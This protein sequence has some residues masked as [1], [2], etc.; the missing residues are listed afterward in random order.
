MNA[1]DLQP[2]PENIVQTFRADALGRNEDIFAFVDLLKSIKSNYS[3]ALDGT[4]GS[5]KTFFV[6]QLVMFLDVYTDNQSSVYKDSFQE[7]RRYLNSD[8]NYEPQKIHA[9]Y[10]DAWAN[11]NDDDPILSIIFNILQSQ[12][13]KMDKATDWKGILGGIANIITGRP[14][15]D[16]INVAPKDNFLEEIE[17]TKNIHALVNS[18]F[19]NLFTSTESERIVIFI[20]EL[21]RCKPSYAITL[22]ERIKHY[23]THEKITFVFSTNLNELQYTVK[24]CYGSEFSGY[25]YLEKF[26]TIIYD[27]AKVD[28]DKINHLLKIPE[29]THLFI[30]IMS[31]IKSYKLQL[32]EALKYTTHLKSILPQE[33]SSHDNYRI[34]SK[35]EG[36]K[37]YIFIP[38]LI[39]LKIHNKKLYDDFIDGDDSSPLITIF[40]DTLMPHYINMLFADNEH[41][42]DEGRTEAMIKSKLQQLYEGIFKNQSFGSFGQMEIPS[43]AKEDLLRESQKINL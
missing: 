41:K 15:T 26:F 11:D 35:Y 30:T 32:R 7:I 36:F 8:G 38:I 29:D 16:L 22:L 12:S 37:N 6:K 42:G 33:D 27:L 18:F 24:Q 13:V 20:D 3:I 2:T 23:F 40:L 10:Y 4:W 28:S 9:V 17:K 34:P 39:G 1:P 43:T 5:G 19:E 14:I 21:D 25:K 31:F